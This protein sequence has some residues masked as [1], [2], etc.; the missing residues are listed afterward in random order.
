[1][2]HDTP[3]P[4]KSLGQHFL[5]NDS[6]SRRIVN[7]LRVQ[8][9]D[10]VLEIGP[11]PGALTCYLKKFSPVNLLLLEKDKYWAFYQAQNSASNTNVIL[12][13]ALTMAWNKLANKGEWKI[14]GNLPYNVA[15]PLIWDIVSKCF[16]WKRLVFM[17]QKEVAE[18]ICAKPGKKDY[19]A[20]SVWTQCH[21]NPKLEFCV[22]PGSF[23]P[24][25]KVDSAVVSFEPLASN[26]KNFSQ[27]SLRD[28]LKIC[29]Q[30]RRKQLGGIFTRANLGHILHRMSVLD[31]DPHLRPENL[32]CEDFINLSLP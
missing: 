11:G 27:S 29:F 19:G 28:L 2:I 32:S 7:I 24:M 30:N 5:I 4:K 31:I 23:R 16:C 12:I 3:F 25:P 14:T 13:D 9:T 10:N 17:V 22:A 21:S 20:L 26:K 18:R 15:S 6:V 8:Q 1:M